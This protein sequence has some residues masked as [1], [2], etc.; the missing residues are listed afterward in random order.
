MITAVLPHRTRQQSN[1]QLVEQYQAAIPLFFLAYNQQLHF[2][3]AMRREDV[4]CDVH[5]MKQTV[6]LGLAST[7]NVFEG[8]LTAFHVP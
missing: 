8:N 2:T 5:A 3:R 4:S 7:T 1:T 6:L